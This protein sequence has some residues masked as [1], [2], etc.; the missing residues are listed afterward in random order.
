MLYLV[1]CGM[2]S[3]GC[4]TTPV[5]PDPPPAVCE[6]SPPPAR[7]RLLLDGPDEGCP[8]RYEVCLDLDAAAELRRWLDLQAAWQAEMEARCGREA[9]SV[10]REAARPP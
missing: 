3:A 9:R 2:L 4:L 6:W 5:L 10:P 8:L 7:P 1:M